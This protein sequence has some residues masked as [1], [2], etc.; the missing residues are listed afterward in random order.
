VAT[1]LGEVFED[2]GLVARIKDRLPRLFQMAEMECSRAG[3]TGMQVGSL[4]EIILVAM[5]IYKFGEENVETGIPITR[6]EVDAMLFGL[7]VSIKTITGRR[8]GGVKLVWTVDPQKAREFAEGYHPHC[9]ILLTQI[10]WGY[11][12][13][14]CH[15]PLEVQQRHFE[16]LGQ[17]TYIRLPKPGTNPRGVEIDKE[18]MAAMAADADT[19]GV[20]VIWHRMDVRHNAYEKWIDLWR[21]D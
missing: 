5:L 3:K 10:N 1:R 12:G 9:D 21:E 11:A 20:T 15:I 19:K 18:A 13:V 16:R 7:P 14:L 4:R 17:K 8:F 6:P 2:R